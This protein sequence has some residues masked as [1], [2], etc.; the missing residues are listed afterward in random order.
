MLDKI[1]EIRDC[2]LAGDGES[3][4]EIIPE[5]DA[6]LGAG[7]GEAEESIAAISSAVATRAA[8]DFSLGHLTANV[9]L[10]AVGV[11]GNFG[12]FEHHQQ[13]GLVGV[14]ARE[15]AIEGDEP[16]ALREEDAIEACSQGSLAPG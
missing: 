1:G 5:C 7:F 14:Q 9:V 12:P 4:A 11:E 8:A 2:G 6:E 16:G 13:F 10:G 15:Q 3:G